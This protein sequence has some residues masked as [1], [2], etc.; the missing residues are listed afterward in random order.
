MLLLGIILTAI[1]EPLL[2]IGMFLL[3]S[4]I[5]AAVWGTLFAVILIMYFGRRTYKTAVAEKSDPS[6]IRFWHIARSLI[7]L[8]EIALV[9]GIYSYVIWM[10]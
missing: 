5:S 2:A 3:W 8:L 7:F 1:I 6:V 10:S 9:I 4:R